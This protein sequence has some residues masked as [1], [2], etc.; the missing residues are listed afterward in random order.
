M[1]QEQE[2]LRTRGDVRSSSREMSP[3]LV[4][5]S[6]LK[7]LFWAEILLRELQKLPV[8][9]VQQLRL[10]SLL[11]KEETTSTGTGESCTVNRRV[12]AGAKLFAFCL[13][14]IATRSYEEVDR[15]SHG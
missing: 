3:F 4:K 9:R 8:Q 11:R 6:N 2:S 13:S 1:N 12:V 14:S 7:R 10:N 15:M 5:M